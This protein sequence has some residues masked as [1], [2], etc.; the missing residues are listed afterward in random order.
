MRCRMEIAEN[1]KTTFCLNSPA[2][3]HWDGK[4]LPN[5][6]GHERVDRLPVI[7]TA[8]GKSQLLGVPC[9][10]SGSGENQASAIY[11][12]ICEWN[13][14]SKIGAMCFDTTASNTGEKS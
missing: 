7:V 1:I 5:I 13:L 3:I 11:K 2:I 8:G 9:I 14:S 10:D 12:L 4:L 6:T